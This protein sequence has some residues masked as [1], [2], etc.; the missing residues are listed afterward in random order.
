MTTNQNFLDEFDKILPKSESKQQDYGY[1]YAQYIP[2]MTTK[3]EQPREWVTEQWTNS[4]NTEGRGTHVETLPDVQGL[5]ELPALEYLQRKIYEG[6]AIPKSYMRAQLQHDILKTQLETIPKLIV[7]A[8]SSV[9][10]EMINILRANK[11]DAAME[12]LG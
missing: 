2:T 3:I 5:G 8:D 9:G 4:P 6:L 1:F 11:F 10:K 12:L 7:D